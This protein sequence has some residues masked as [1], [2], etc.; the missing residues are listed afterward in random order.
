LVQYWF[1][2]PQIEVKPKPH[3]N[4][5]SSQ[6]YFR[7]S[8]TAKSRHREI[9]E[10]NTPK[11]VMEIATKEQGGELEARG[12]SNLPRNLQQLKNYRWGEQKKDG[13]V[14][15][16]VMLQCKLCEGKEGSFVRD[17]KAAPDPQCVLFTDWQISDLEC[18]A[19]DSKQ[20]CIFTAE[21]TYN[22]GDFYVTPTT[23]QHLLL[24]S[25]R[26]GKHPIFIGP[27]L[28]HQRKNFSAFNYFASTLVG[29]SKKLRE[30]CAFG[31]DGDQAMVEALAH[32]FPAF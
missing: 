10:R 21:T 9:A 27:I 2:G 24:E 18:F 26:S 3:V 31:T 7:T 30:I 16:S 17:V 4:S 13:N 29:H 1:D 20:Y 5:K 15:Y 14:L 25:V 11:V 19:T 12:L 22:L 32:N 28:I 6:P 23:Y 8:E